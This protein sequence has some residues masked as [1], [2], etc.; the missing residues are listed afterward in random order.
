MLVYSALEQIDYEGC[1][2]LGVF[3][4]AADAE[5]FIRSYDGFVRQVSGPSYGG[6]SYGYV[7]SEL[8]QPVDFYRDVVYVE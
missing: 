2:L 8:G 5:Q 3:A 6:H 4:S 7:E 1:D